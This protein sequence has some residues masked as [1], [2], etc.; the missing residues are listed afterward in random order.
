[1]NAI[2]LP[3]DA[4]SRT[5][6]FAIE[7]MTCASCVARI[8]R[9]LR[10][11]PGVVEAAV[12]LATERASVRVQAHVGDADL[13]AAVNGAGYVAKH[14]ATARHDDATRSGLSRETR[15]VLWAALLSAPLVLPMVGILFDKHW[16]LPGWWQL[17]FAAPVQFWLGA[18][19]YKAAWRAMRAGTGN[20]DLLVALG[21]TAG[22]GLSLFNLVRGP[23]QHGAVP[24]YFETSAAVITL[25]LL[26]KWL[27]GRARRQATDAIRAL[28]ALRPNRV[29]VVR[30]GVERELPIESVSAGDLVVVLAGERFPV[31]GD[32]L[33]GRTHA[34]ESLVTGE[35]L[36]AAKAAGDRVI[37]GAVNGEGRVVVRTIAVGADSLLSQIIRMVEDAQGRKAPIQQVVDRVSAIFVPIVI[38]LALATLAAWGLSTGDWSVAI[39]HAVAVLVIAC[40]CALG[41]ATPTA[42][43]AGTG[44]AARAGI[45]IKDADVLELARQVDIVAFDKTGTLTE[46]R[47]V[48]AERIAVD[49]DARAL[50]RL[51]TAL[52]A[53]SEHPLAKA[54]VAAHEGAPTVA[55][56]VQAVPGRGIRGTVEGRA[57]FLGSTAWMREEGVDVS[58]LRD[59][60][61][62]LANS[63]HSVSW[64]AERVPDGARLI[65]LMSFRDQPRKQ[66][67][68]AIARLHAMG[69]R[70]IM[71]SGDNRGAA[72]TVAHALGIDQVRAEVLP[73][74]KADVV[75]A[76]QR[77]GRVAMVGDG[78]N[79]APALAAADVGIAMGSGTDV[80][81]HAA[82]VTLMR[83]DPA[84]VAAA[85]DISRRTTRK[86]HQN[87]FWAFGYNIVG[88]PLAAL[89]LLDPVIAGAAMAFSSVSV[90][91]NTLLLRRWSPAP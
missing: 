51:A 14:I 27:E 6:E 30:D 36:P 89:G 50:L 52:Q 31:D 59:Q 40:P 20:M 41:L 23:D 64:L 90:L 45:L 8:E 87:L 18:R 48:L 91:S 76:L 37:G 4:A 84:L 34:D 83:P 32:I 70:T 72:R 33:E 67:K 5:S 75:R 60:Q 62:L 38:V 3:A 88:I 42:V 82:G 80:A 61:A 58:E 69:L 25:I 54:V 19:F 56:D 17:A 22:F 47:P 77:E 53:G 15:H 81:M 26:G 13:H 86:I 24:L 10:K 68:D 29:R 21:T 65:G 43:M 28:Q 2:A 85:I 11:V 1:M 66:A 49:G 46:G 63:G 57:L 74:D 35:S 79:D 78:I 9:A 73:G 55:G 44:V 16:M 12:N 71:L 7:G 39:L